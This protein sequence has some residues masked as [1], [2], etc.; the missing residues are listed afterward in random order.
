MPDAANTLAYDFNGSLWTAPAGT[1]LPTYAAF[2]PV[3]P[4]P[5][6]VPAPPW[7]NTGFVDEAGPDFETKNDTNSLRA[8]QS[9]A[10]VRIV[11]K[12]K[13]S[14]LAFNLL[15]WT[16]DNL[17]FALGVEDDGTGLLVP[18]SVP[19]ERAVLIIVTDGGVRVGIGFPR[20]SLILDAKVSFKPADWAMLPVSLTALQPADDSPSFVV[21]LPA[22]A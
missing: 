7:I 11:N 17:E 15:E 20:G 14:T 6:Y 22:A 1:A 12:A 3:D 9:F 18:S 13:T 21:Y 10:D 5:A 4:A 2:F 8:W 16:A 19:I